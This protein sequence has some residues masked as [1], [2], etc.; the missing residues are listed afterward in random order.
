M[1]RFVN[2]C[3][4]NI[5]PKRLKTAASKMAKTPENFPLCALKF[6][7]FPLPRPIQPPCLASNAM[8]SKTENVKSKMY[9]QFYI[10]Y[11]LFSPL[12]KYGHNDYYLHLL[13]LNPFPLLNSEMF[14][15]LPK[16]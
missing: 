14:S 1:A 16:P 7:R 15:L 11:P 5:N 6:K 8:N 3:A 12:L 9:G 13:P 4:C 10:L 2:M